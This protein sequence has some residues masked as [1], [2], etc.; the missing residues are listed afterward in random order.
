VEVGQFEEGGQRRW[1]G[2]NDSVSAR[3]RRRRD[4]A[5]SEN[6]ADAV[7]SS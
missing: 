1:C 7:S 5:L 2:F 4:K 6:E 3:E